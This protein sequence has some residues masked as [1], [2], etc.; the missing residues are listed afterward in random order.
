M[1][2]LPHASTARSRT[3]TDSLRES[4]T[5]LRRNLLQAWRYPSMIVSIIVMPVILLLVFAFVFGGALEM[6][7]GGEYIDY[8]TPGMLLLI[9]AYLMASLAVQIATDTTKGIV[10]R[11]R[12]MP[13]APS[14]ML[15]G[16]VG[17]TLVLGILGTGAMALVG[18][19]IG[20]RPN[21]NPLEWLAAFGLLALF[22]LALSWIAV[23][24]GL[25]S[26][27][28]ESAS[29]LPMPFILLPFL[30][31]GLVATDT[32]PAGLRQFAEYQPFTPLTETIRG[33]L[34]GTEIGGSAVAA[35]AWC[36]GLGLIGFVWSARVFTRQDR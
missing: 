6:A 8:L 26:P 25:I 35:L 3:S 21:A 27:N 33:L 23:G 7:S 34:M 1:T 28:P 30:G 32:M 31:S 29:N 12:T 36:A 13:I 11:F 16:H 14:S 2:T 10:N 15:A 24:M 19:L 9:P 17:G 4:W 18:L 22:T 20:W 5:M